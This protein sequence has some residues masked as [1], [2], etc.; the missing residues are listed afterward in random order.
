MLKNGFWNFCS[1]SAQ[2]Q[3]SQPR[4]TTEFHPW[5][6]ANSL[7]PE[8]SVEPGW[9]QLR[10]QSLTDWQPQ[11]RG[12]SLCCCQEVSWSS[13]KTNENM[14]IFMNTSSHHLNHHSNHF[15]SF[16]I[17]LMIAVCPV[18]PFLQP[19][20]VPKA[21]SCFQGETVVGIEDGKLFGASVDQN[22][23]NVSGRSNWPTLTYW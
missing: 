7:A 3:T 16:T 18:L 4:L 13:R 12:S 1:Q 14:N 15:Q 11:K 2:S 19:K 10:M 9:P 6:K 23:K 5:H 20:G 17:G 21:T 22:Q 8:S